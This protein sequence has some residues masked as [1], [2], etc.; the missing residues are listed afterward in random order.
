M[1]TSLK[2]CIW[3]YLPLLALAIL[4]I[5]LAGHAQMTT[6][7]L[8]G[9]VSDTSGAR[10]QGATV[11]IINL[12]TGLK[13]SATSDADGSYTFPRLA[14][15]NY[16]LHA[17]RTGFQDYLQTGVSLTVGQ[18]ASVAISMKVGSA[19]S[20]VTVTA[21]APLVD[22][23]TPTNNQVVGEQQAVDLPLNGR[24][25]Q[26]L[27]NI[28]PGTINPARF[29]PKL[30][31]QGGYYP[32]E[33]TY[34]VNGA[35]PAGV[36][37]QMDG[38]PHNDTYL[39]A[40]QPF[41]DPDAIQE[42]GVQSANFSAEYGHAAGGIV[43]IITKSGTNRFHGDAFEFLRNGSLDAR[44]YFGKAPDTLH[45]NQFGGVLGGPI[46]RN[47]LFFFGSYQQTPS[48]QGSNENTTFVPS[49]AERTGDF[50]AIQKQL[51]DPTTGAPLTNNQIPDLD[52]TA[53]ALLKYVPLPSPGLSNGELIYSGIPSRTSD[54]QALGKLSYIHGNSQLT[55]DYFFSQ[56]DQP[57]IIPTTNILQSAGGNFVR[58]QSVALGYTYAPSETLLFNTSFGWTSQTGGSTS[59]APLSWADLGAKVAHPNPPE[60]MLGISSGFSIRTNH[61]GMFDRYN[62]VL[63]EDVTKIAG[64]HE[65]HFGG[66]ALHASVNLVNTFQQ[67]GSYSF[68]G[69]LSGNGLADFM[70]GAAS[71]FSQ[72][73]GQYE[74]VAGIYWSLFA[75]DNWRVT[76]RLTLDL[77]LRWDPWL[78]F[79]D[80]DG[81]VLCWVPGGGTSVRYPNAPAGLLYGGDAGC[82]TTGVHSYWPEFGP[83]AGF[84]Y[85]I[86]RNGNNSIRGGFGTYYNTVPMTDY[87]HVATSAP[88]SPQFSLSDV[89]FTDPYQSA[90]ITNPFPAQY[91][92]TT[93]DSSATFVLPT[94]I[95]AF[96]ENLRP[97]TSYSYN[98]IVDHGIGKHAVASIAYLGSLSR[99]LSDN[100][101]N[102]GLQRQL[103]AAVYIP[104][105]STEANTQQRRPY[106]AF[107][108]IN[109]QQSELSG[110]YNALQT[111]FRAR[112]GYGNTVIGSYTW[113][114]A[115]AE[116]GW[117]D[118]HDA[119][120]NYGPA[121]WNLNNN[122]KF[123]DVWSVPTFHMG[124]GIEKNV[125]NGWQLNA[126]V[127]W[128]SGI[129][130]TVMSGVDNSFS[131]VG[132]DHAEY[133][134]GPVTLTTHRSH[135]AM[136]QQWFNT[137][138]FA[139][140]TVGT[141]GTASTGQ[142]NAPR[143]F[144]TDLAI[145]KNMAIWE[146]VNL[147]LRLHAYNAFNNVDFNYPQL[148]QNSSSFGKITSAASPRI[149]ELG[150]RI[151]F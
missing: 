76:D 60:L 149:L 9:T 54:I 78:P 124:N 151:A 16:E 130:L 34:S 48:S 25:T 137:A 103:D 111:S 62:W 101:S 66:E 115:F 126:I 53:L 63:R 68:S 120:F 106:S 39:N 65:L 5:S 87:N 107:S 113:G 50:S 85:R 36:N 56:Y 91:G 150:A 18:A 47:K 98:L 84:A 102:L 119:H 105:A 81:R 33:A 147:Q 140:N 17:T 88:F 142:F 136:T 14:V 110:N 94:S 41:P 21:N 22:T 20:T 32:D 121:T 71:S 52:P 70:F 132:K 100:N 117:D 45:R 57:A 31:G 30:S 23:L 145:V 37:Y 12:G 141:F 72:G 46:L 38:V 118:P 131:G 67:A 144:D 4:G 13:K 73:G 82:P 61:E 116:N 146:G 127:L 40:G 27:V 93:P 123:S 24:D 3:L 2:S 58:V 139:P 128:Q 114:R 83:R 99:H 129:P 97:A 1:T 74:N 10:I 44:N 90:G 19:A 138:A 80:R 7:S 112:V 77:G 122:L 28:A 35:D 95:G 109:E 143:Y 96:S 92:P 8:Q 51:H 15:G 148:S 29:G 11:T 79:Y 69:Q 108:G 104:G 43:N 75:Q 89:N 134:G 86:T 42:F 49:A 26:D 59:G 55:G 125:I 6:A 133:L 64:K 135:R